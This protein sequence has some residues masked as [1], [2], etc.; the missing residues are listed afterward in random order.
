[1]RNPPLQP[2][3]QPHP[4]YLTKPSGDENDKEAFERSE[5]TEFVLLLLPELTPPSTERVEQ[6]PKEAES[7][8][9]LHHPRSSLTPSRFDLFDL[10]PATC[11]FLR[12]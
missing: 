7:V 10:Q 12:L 9:R 3:R 1:M 4:L 8:Q 5:F 6:P 11:C 2:T